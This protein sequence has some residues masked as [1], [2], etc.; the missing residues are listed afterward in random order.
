MSSA[1]NRG[2]GRFYLHISNI[3]ARGGNATLR[4]PSH[5]AGS[6]SLVAGVGQLLFPSAWLCLVPH[7]HLC[8][9]EL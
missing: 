3:S 6:F 8:L 2:P 4:R 1:L 7:H 5:L 9:S